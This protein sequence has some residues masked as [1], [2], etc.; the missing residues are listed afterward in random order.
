MTNQESVQVFVELGLSRLEAEIYVFLVQHP[1][2]TG[3]KVAKGIG[4]PN[5]NTY[6]AIE[7]LAA[8]G[9]ILVDDGEN[10]LCRAVPPEEL[11]DQMER[12]FRERKRRAS[13]NIKSITAKTDDDRVYQ[14]NTVDQVYTRC[15]RMLAGCQTTALVDA[16]P[17]PLAALEDAIAD[18]VSRGV[19]VALQVYE[20][21]AIP[22]AEVVIHRRAAEVMDRWPGQWL[23]A[24]TDGSQQLIAF[25]ATGGQAVHQA[26]W[27][28]SP[29][30][31]WAFHSLAH[32]ELLLSVLV[33]Q[34]ES[35]ASGEELRR[36]YRD[37]LARVP[38]PDAP[39]RQFPLVKPVLSPPR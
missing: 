18:A 1:L 17:E 16:F 21:V 25:L 4:R 37:W 24:A 8:K 6:K 20:Q 38:Y 14:L 29:I 10:R 22:G 35:G 15:R 34:L 33:H 31:S 5:S 30:V 12:R 26:V 7:S 2:A 13:E 36:T 19:R 32:S 39:K 27:S 11:L 28:S 3:Y 9:A 23:E